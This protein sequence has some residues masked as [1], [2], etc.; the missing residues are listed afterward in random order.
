[1]S[2]QQIDFD[3]RPEFNLERMRLVRLQVFLLMQTFPLIDSG[4]RFSCS[5]QGRALH[6]LINTLLKKKQSNWTVHSYTRTLVIAQSGL[7]FAQFFALKKK[8]FRY[9]D[10]KKTFYIN[11]FNKKSWK[12]RM[13]RVSKYILQKVFILLHFISYLFILNMP[14]KILKAFGNE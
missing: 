14:P 1:M 12:V 13:K 11:K 9:K 7:T 4:C 3:L 2:H 6:F 5:P 8:Q 10:Q